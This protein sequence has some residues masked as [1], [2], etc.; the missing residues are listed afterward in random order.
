MKVE[1][2]KVTKLKL[3]DLDRLDPI[4][5]FLEDFE[6]RK[7]K[8]TIECF[9]K[10]WSSYWGGMGDRTI[11][12]FFIDCDNH[13]LAKNLSSISSTVDDYEE[14]VNVARSTI[15][16]R[17]KQC[18]L[19]QEEAREMFDNINDARYEL[20]DDDG[21]AWCKMNSDILHDI[22][23]DDWWYSI[24]QKENHEYQ[25]LSLIIDAVREGLKQVTTAKA[26]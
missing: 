16:Q 22:F 24:P 26:A 13:Y 23:G 18:E 1:Q 11:A 10:S 8:I 20:N 6:P 2:S 4:T 9:G 12:Q 25:Y 5:I 17:R 14:F 3:T 15:I 19:E 7:G 21:L